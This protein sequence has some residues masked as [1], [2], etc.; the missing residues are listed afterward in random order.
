ME[1]KAVLP[2]LPQTRV[3]EAECG[4]RALVLLAA[5]NHPLK[6]GSGG[7]TALVSTKCCAQHE[8]A[9]RSASLGLPS[10]P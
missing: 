10:I 1:R 8:K 4:G 6:Q 7:D 2:L 5:Q 9:S 3:D